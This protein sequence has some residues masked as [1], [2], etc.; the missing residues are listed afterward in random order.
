MRALSRLFVDEKICRM[1]NT[2]IHTVS[3]EWK[4]CL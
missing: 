3:I 4:E 2:H 1:Y